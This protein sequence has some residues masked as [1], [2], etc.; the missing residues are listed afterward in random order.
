MFS[1]LPFVRVRVLAQC[2]YKASNEIEACVTQA[3]LEESLVMTYVN[4]N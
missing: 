4:W 1:S 2:E 3:V